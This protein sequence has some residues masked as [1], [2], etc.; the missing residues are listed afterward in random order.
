LR[1]GG[2]GRGEDVRRAARAG[3]TPRGAFP[4][5][6]PIVAAAGKTALG[7]RLGETSVHSV[8]TDSGLTSAGSHQHADGAFGS[9]QAGGERGA[10]AGKAQ[11]AAHER[12]HLTRSA[13]SASAR[14]GELPGSER[15][16]SAAP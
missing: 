11:E 3:G 12:L 1:A 15:R 16:H 2:G 4:A 8:R 7:K 13:A 9:V 6:A 10:L 5:S 14:A